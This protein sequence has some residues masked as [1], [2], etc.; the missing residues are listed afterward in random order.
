MKMLKTGQTDGGRTP[1]AGVIGILLPHPKSFG[2]G[3]QETTKKTIC[4]QVAEQLPI[5]LKSPFLS[6][7]TM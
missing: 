7:S 1:D 2:S 6:S 3:E 5:K 4:V